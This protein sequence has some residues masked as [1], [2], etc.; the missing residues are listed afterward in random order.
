MRNRVKQLAEA[1]RGLRGQLRDLLDEFG[2]SLAQCTSN[3]SE[4]DQQ[5][6]GCGQ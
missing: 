4:K 5:A 6:D 1:V 3:D 2:G